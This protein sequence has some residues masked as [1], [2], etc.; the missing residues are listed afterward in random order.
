MSATSSP[1]G[2]RTP[3]ALASLGL[4]AAGGFVLGW[5]LPPACS[6]TFEQVRAVLDPI[7]MGT[8]CIGLIR[9]QMKQRRAT[10]VA[11]LLCGCSFV[12]MVLAVI[13]H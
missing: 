11:T 10:I 6:R 1:V 9:M 4:L 3:L 13:R 8:I 2:Q 5:L 12:A 7:C